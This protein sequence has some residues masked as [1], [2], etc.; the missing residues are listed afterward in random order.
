MGQIA[1]SKRT[2][3][4]MLCDF[5]VER[6]HFFSHDCHCS[7]YCKKLILSTFGKRNLTHLKTNVMLSGQRF[8]ILAMFKKRDGVN[9]C[10]ERLLN[11]CVVRG[12]VIFLTHSL[13]KV[14][15]F[16]F[17]SRLYDFFCEE[18]VWLFCWEIAWIF[19]WRGC[20]I[21]F[22]KRLRDFCVK[23]CFSKK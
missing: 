9:L 22:V 15:W 21:F 20:L 1:F 16:I 6:S 14:A 8:A 10:M 2:E 11:F 7:H 13:T 5:F 3:K 4:K 23:R 19:V 18:V 12:C 17:F